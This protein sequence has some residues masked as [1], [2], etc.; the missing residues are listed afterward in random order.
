[1]SGFDSEQ[2]ECAI[3]IAMPRVCE[4]RKLWFADAIRREHVERSLRFL[5]LVALVLFAIGQAGR[6]PV[7]EI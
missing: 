2:K 1:M 7:D 6:I 3:A 5:P 4:L